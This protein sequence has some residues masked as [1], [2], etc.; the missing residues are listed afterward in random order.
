MDLYDQFFLPSEVFVSWRKTSE[1]FMKMKV[2]VLISIII[3][4]SFNINAQDKTEDLEHML[5]QNIEDSIRVKTLSTLAWKLK[6][7]DVDKA[8]GFVEEAFDLSIKIGHKKEQARALQYLSVI[9]NEKGQYAKAIEYAD[10]AIQLAN[11]LGNTLII[12]HSNNS[13]GLIYRAK[14]ENK[15]AIG[16]YKKAILNYKKTST[17]AESAKAFDFLTTVKNNIGH[18]YLAMSEYDSSRVCY[19]EALDRVIPKKD[20]VNIQRT[21]NS[22]AITYMEQ[23]D[24]STAFNYYFKSMEIN[25]KLNNQRSLEFNWNNLGNAYYR[26]ED[27]GKAIF[28]HEKNLTSRLK[29]N[30]RKGVASSYN[31]IGLCYLELG[32]FKMGTQCFKKSIEICETIESKEGLGSSLQNMGMTLQAQGLPSRAEPYFQQGLRAHK[33]TGSQ[34]GIAMSLEQLAKIAFGQK[35]YRKSINLATQSL[36]ISEEIGI[37][38]IEKDSYQWLA[39]SSE[40]LKRF[41]KSTA[42]YKSYS[43]AIEALLDEDKVKAIAQSIARYDLGKKDTIIASQTEEIKSLN[44]ESIYE[45]SRGN[46]FLGLTILLGSLILLAIFHFRQKAKY[47]KSKTELEFSL[48]QMQHEM[49]SRELKV[50]ED[51]LR[52]YVLMVNEKNEVV[53]SLQKKIALTQ[54]GQMSISPETYLELNQSVQDKLNKEKDWEEFQKHFNQIHVG[55]LNNFATM[56][57]GLT[58]HELRL[59]ALIRL[60]MPNK[61]IAKLLNIES[62]SVKKAKSRLRKKLEINTAEALSAYIIRFS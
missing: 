55:F 54:N 50:K 56:H 13:K 61:E 62:D 5:N 49:V 4:L 48:T 21:Y 10:N 46:L 59:T 27:F 47:L 39:K 52:K 24:L 36:K 3:F 51:E 8:M 17:Y 7:K 18:T 30:N 32:D 33:I 11:E 40:Y 38:Q 53:D 58:P 43:E 6:Y 9:L 20:S 22:I 45:K 28:Y 15:K 44:E 60:N 16:Y 29:R 2:K 41:D 31:N 25:E 42:Y 23:G 34:K 12:A 26:I 1:Y 37:L 57:E 19:F 14:G 35:Q